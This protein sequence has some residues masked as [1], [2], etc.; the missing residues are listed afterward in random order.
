[1]K[2]RLPA[3]DFIRT[4]CTLIIVTYHYSCNLNC[5]DFLP[6]YLSGSINWGT[7]AVSVFFMISG[8]LLYYNNP[9]IKPDGLKKYFIKRWKTVFPLFY[10]AYAALFAAN[11]VRHG[12][13]FIREIHLCLFCRHWA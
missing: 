10:I 3:F 7:T 2:E 11:A 12:S 1:M 4:V 6:L 8:S 13:V 9:E 5:R